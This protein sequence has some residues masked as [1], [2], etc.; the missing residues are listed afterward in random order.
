MDLTP[1]TDAENDYQKFWRIDDESPFSTVYEKFAGGIKSL[2]F[3]PNVE[4][5]GDKTVVAGPDGSVNLPKGKFTLSMKVWAASNR[6]LRKIHVMLKSPN[7]EIGTFDLSGLQS[8]KWV[9]L[10][11][12]FDSEHGSNEDDRMEISVQKADMSPNADAG[13][14]FIDEISIRAANR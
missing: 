9:T 7:Q 2:K 11:Q 5:A 3:D 13:P 4:I 1:E 8:G 10:T 14:V 12:S 6:P